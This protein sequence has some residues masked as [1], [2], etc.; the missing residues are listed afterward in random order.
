M[1]VRQDNM[2]DNNQSDRIRQIAGWGIIG[3]DS[4]NRGIDCAVPLLRTLAARRLLLPFLLPISFW[5]ARYHLPD[6]HSHLHSKVVFRPV[7]RRKRRKLLLVPTTAK[8]G[9][10]VNC[11][12]EICK[13]R[14]NKRAV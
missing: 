6:F 1:E 13:G 5:L 4:R 2:S 12:R 8:T 7:E 11:Q 9:R 14:N 10:S 3:F